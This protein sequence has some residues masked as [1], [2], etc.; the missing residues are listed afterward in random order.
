MNYTRTTTQIHLHG[1]VTTDTKHFDI[2]GSCTGQIYGILKV[3]AGQSDLHLFIESSAQAQAIT[4]ALAELA[5]DLAIAEVE[6][7]NALAAAEAEQAEAEQAAAEQ[8]AAEQ[9][10]AEQALDGCTCDPVAGSHRD[11]CAWSAMHTT[12]ADTPTRYADPF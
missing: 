10:A 2:A 4:A 7:D 1:E 6:R 3:A 12:P 8:A 5:N 9:A 11:G